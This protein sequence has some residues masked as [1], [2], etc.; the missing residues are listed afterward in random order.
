MCPRNFFRISKKVSEFLK[1]VSVYPAKF[2]TAIQN[3]AADGDRYFMGSYIKD[4]RG[5]TYET[6]KESRVK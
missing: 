3:Y 4:C 6:L 2:K 5:F 1:K